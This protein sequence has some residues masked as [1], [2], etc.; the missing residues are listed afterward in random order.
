[1]T[2]YLETV[3]YGADRAL[4][5]RSTQQTA[6]AVSLIVPGTTTSVTL[7]V[8]YIEIR[9]K[10]VIQKKIK[11]RGRSFDDVVREVS[12][13]FKTRGKRLAPGLI[14]ETLIRIG[15]PRARSIL[16][17]PEEEGPE[18]SVP[19]PAG[20]ASPVV[21]PSGTSGDTQSVPTA[22]TRPQTSVKPERE[23]RPTSATSEE[24]PVAT[25]GRVS[26]ELKATASARTESDTGQSVT[27]GSD[28]AAARTEPPTTAEGAATPGN[29]P[30]V[31]TGALS[32]EE[33][34]DIVEA[35]AAVEKISDEFEVPP[36][37]R[38]PEISIKIEGQAELKASEKT[39]AADSEEIV[40]S[41]EEAAK[42]AA[43]E[44]TSERASAA[45][46]VVAEEPI[47][48]SDGVIKPEVTRK[49]IVLGEDG[50]GK[51]SLL[52]AESDSYPLI[53]GTTP[54]HVYQ[55]L[56]ETPTHR[57]QLRSWSFD[58]AAKAGV[59]RREYYSDTDAV[60]IVYAVDDRWS[61]N[62][63]DFWVKE[64]QSSL[65]HLPPIVIVGNK[66]DMRGGESVGATVS[67]DEGYK[68]AESLAHELS[69]GEGLHKVAFVETS[70]ITG[71]GIDKLFYTAARFATLD[72]G[73]ASDSK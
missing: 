71:E 31:V 21:G 27:S 64:V 10:G 5:A 13:Y 58:D 15:V 45:R 48:D 16:V 55:R 57:V 32:D 23:V 11:I 39:H 6:E 1:M 14:E 26:V 47:T 20:P 61:F 2:Q 69:S 36:E 50:V 17:G 8:G 49:V 38:A 73:D 52:H 9:D 37:P 33:I 24:S 12:A 65:D 72:S 28:E 68:R 59:S 62:S 18:E 42:E 25:S 30:V 3:K 41:A 63:I 51:S 7:A 22:E 66:V 34:G 4:H 35:L 44:Q 29:R 53:T 60:L 43:V 46:V 67:R 40:R 54:G 56:V 70:C 19:K